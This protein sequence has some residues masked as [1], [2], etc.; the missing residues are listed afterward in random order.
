MIF[1]LYSVHDKTGEV[2]GTP[3]FARNHTDAAR[4][5]ANSA[6]PGTPVGD[7]PDEFELVWVGAFDDETG[8]LTDQPLQAL[9]S[10]TDFIR[11][12]P[13]LVDDTPLSGDPA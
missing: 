4:D 5:F 9:G 13:A 6:K 10:A 7:Y 8:H 2:Y 11:G 3:F 12:R 1:N